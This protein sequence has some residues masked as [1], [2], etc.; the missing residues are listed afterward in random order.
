MGSFSGIGND[1]QI[2]R[3]IGIDDAGH[4]LEW[5]IPPEISGSDCKSDGERR[6]QLFR[7]HRFRYL[8]SIDSDIHLN[9]HIL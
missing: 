8:G 6:G 4:T 5:N 3:E 2:E 7:T 9:N 1:R